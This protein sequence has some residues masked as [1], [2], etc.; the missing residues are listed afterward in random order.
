MNNSE[1]PNTAQIK[2]CLETLKKLNQTNGWFLIH[3]HDAL[4][5]V[6]HALENVLHFP[7]K[8]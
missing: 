3:E 5:E 6:I 7:S 2:E 8:S 1:I 4:S